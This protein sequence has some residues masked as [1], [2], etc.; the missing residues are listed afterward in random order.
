M[1]GNSS[2]RGFAVLL[3]KTLV[4]FGSQ[5]AEIA[6]RSSPNRAR[7]LADPTGKDQ[8]I[9][10]VESSAEAKNCFG[11]TVAENFDSETRAGVALTDRLHKGAHIIAESRETE[12]AALAIKN[13]RDPSKVVIQASR[14]ELMKIGVDVPAS[15]PHYETL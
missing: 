14:Q 6:Q 11:Q 3:V 12:K 4:E 13:G 9:N 8:G 15:G 10:T 2:C 5:D 1:T 7:I